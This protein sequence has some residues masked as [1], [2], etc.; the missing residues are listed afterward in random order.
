MAL[1]RRKES[2]PGFVR[3]REWGRD[4]DPFEIMNWNPFQVM[5]EMTK[6]DP[7][8]DFSR[9]GEKGFHASFEVKETKDSYVF[10]ADLPGVKE[11][12][13]D[14]SVTENRLTISGKREEE[15]RDESDR[16]YAYERSYGSFSRAFTL[17]EGV[18]P[19]KVDA[20]FKSGVLTLT[21]PKNPEVKAK[22]IPL[23]SGESKQHAA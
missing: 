5:Q 3:G 15:K 4:W 21:V 18:D 1:I 8:R 12:D 19:D 11:D 17:P 23:R 7:F 9:F 10:K 14:V 20:E 22:H 6:W 16:Y 13:L 2:Q